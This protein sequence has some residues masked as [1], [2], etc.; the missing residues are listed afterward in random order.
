VPGGNIEGKAR[1]D[2]RARRRGLPEGEEGDKREGYYI[3]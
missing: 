3:R 2:E 1:G